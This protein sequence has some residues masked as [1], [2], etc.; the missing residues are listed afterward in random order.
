MNIQYPSKL[1]GR[2]PFFMVEDQNIYLLF[3]VRLRIR[4][5]SPKWVVS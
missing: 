5:L 3:P 1:I 2:E 4:D